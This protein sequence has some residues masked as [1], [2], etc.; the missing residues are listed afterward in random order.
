[1]QLMRRNKNREEENNKGA[2]KWMVTFSD[3]MTLIL[4]FFILLFS[5]SEVD[6]QKFRVLS[7]SFQQRQI[8]EFMQSAIEFEHPGGD[9]GDGSGLVSSDEDE[10]EE[11]NMD[12]L[13]QE[14]QAFLEENDLTDVISATRDDRG[15]V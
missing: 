10:S 9:I 3:M 6:A 12:V 14:A 5:M 11:V 15:V 13:L 1:M 4:V 2:P 8:F 7:E